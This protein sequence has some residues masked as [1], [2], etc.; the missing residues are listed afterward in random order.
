MRNAPPL[1]PDEMEELDEADRARAKQLRAQG[2]SPLYAAESCQQ[3]PGP[4]RQVLQGCL[5]IPY[6]YS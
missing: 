4:K 5:P 3:L 1:L 6:H 2:R